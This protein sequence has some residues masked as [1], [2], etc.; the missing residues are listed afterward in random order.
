MTPYKGSQF[1][2]YQNFEV[3]NYPAGNLT[4]L[5]VG[6]YVSPLNNPENIFLI[7]GGSI[8]DYTGWDQ[9]LSATFENTQFSQ[10]ARISGTKTKLS[11]NTI[12]KNVPEAK[13][14]TITNG[15]NLN[16]EQFE[17][18]FTRAKKSKVATASKKLKKPKLLP[19]QYIDKEGF[20]TV[21]IALINYIPHLLSPEVIDQALPVLNKYI[22]QEYLPYYNVRASYKNYTILPGDVGLPEFDG[23]FIPFF[24]LNVDQFNLETLGSLV[25][26]G[27]ATN[28]NNVPNILAG[29]QI[30][31]YLQATADFSVPVLPLA[32]PYLMISAA[33]FPG[34]V[35]VTTDQ[36]GLGP[37][38][39]VPTGSSTQ[40][41]TT[42][43]ITALGADANPL[44]AC[45]P[46]VNDLSGKIGVN[47]RSSCASSVYPNNMAN[48]GAIAFLTVFSQA[49]TFSA[50]G[51]EIWGATMGPDGFALSDAL[52]TNPNIT[53]TISAPV[54]SARDYNTL[55]EILSHETE[56]LCSDSNYATYVMT[57]NPNVDSAVLFSQYEA[58]DPTEGFNVIATKN[59]HSF[60]MEC[61]PTPSYY[62]AYLRNN[63][64]DNSGIVWRPLVPESRQQV[65]FHFKSGSDAPRNPIHYGEVLGPTENGFAQDLFLQDLGSIFDPQSFY[66]PQTA[67]V[68]SPIEDTP[69]NTIYNALRTLV[70]VLFL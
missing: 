24:L 16:S 9:Q 33:N 68:T 17:K 63:N 58:S 66:P 49:R 35:T 14:S 26:G 19:F 30:N 61:F 2:I 1:V 10:L 40:I 51:A 42:F 29:P 67:S 65:V 59:G 3:T 57:F 54:S 12:E 39:A 21:R 50:T 43:P 4:D 27:G 31:Q 52:A 47:V 7:P 8:Y 70:D 53:V 11:M 44:N 5:L 38:I 15:R 37:F 69:L 34:Q 13:S 64:Y 45:T 23:T 25:V 18:A 62:V 41:P 48:A 56:E 22:K 20:L 60:G 32:N 28:V 36:A 46:L 55:T 6:T